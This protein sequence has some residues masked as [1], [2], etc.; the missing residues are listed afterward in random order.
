[1]NMKKKQLIQPVLAILLIAVLFSCKKD[2]YTIEDKAVTGTFNYVR[3]GFEPLEVDSATQQPL[4]VRISMDGSGSLTDIGNLTFESSFVFDLVAGQGSEFET[5]YVGTDTNNTFK[6]LNASSQMTGN[7]IFVVIE[8]IG[9]GTGKFD[10]IEGGGETLVTLA[11]DGS[12]GSGEVA[13][14]VTY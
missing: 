10:K 8:T 11:L 14:T 12:N 5:T 2:E 1:M 6:C 7:M 4:K 9:E 13:W 3:T